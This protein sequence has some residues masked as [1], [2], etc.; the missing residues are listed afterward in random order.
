M[1]HFF[2]WYQAKLMLGAPKVRLHI[3]DLKFW[4]HVAMKFKRNMVQK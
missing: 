4:V 1:Y 3:L 2:F